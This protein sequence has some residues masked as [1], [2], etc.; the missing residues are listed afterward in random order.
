LSSEEVPEES[1]RRIEAELYIEKT[2]ELVDKGCYIVVA[3]GF[4][5]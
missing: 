4:A 2:G 5:L 1:G 3:R